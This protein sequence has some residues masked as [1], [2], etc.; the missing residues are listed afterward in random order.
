MLIDLY[1]YPLSSST[2]F[3]CRDEKLADGSKDTFSKHIGAQ[4]I[5]WSGASKYTSSDY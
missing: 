3:S 2:E 5:F 1:N 4:V